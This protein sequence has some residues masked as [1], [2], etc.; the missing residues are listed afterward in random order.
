MPGAGTAK[1]LPEL[2]ISLVVATSEPSG[3][4]A[5]LILLASNAVASTICGISTCPTPIR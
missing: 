1:L 2:S 3:P 4:A 5:T